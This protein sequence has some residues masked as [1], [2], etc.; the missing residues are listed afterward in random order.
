[1]SQIAPRA[2]LVSIG[3]TALSSVGFGD[4]AQSHAIDFLALPGEV[5]GLVMPPQLPSGNA[6]YK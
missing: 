4:F 5:P 6:G 1:M 2:I 3:K